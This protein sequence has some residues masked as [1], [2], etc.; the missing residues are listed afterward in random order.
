MPSLRRGCGSV[1]F[2]CLTMCG[3]AACGEDTGTVRDA[4]RTDTSATDGDMMDMGLPSDDVEDS[5]VNDDVV[6]GDDAGD[7]DA[8]PTDAAPPRCGMGID[9]DGDGID[10]DVECLNGTDPFN[11]DSDGDGLTDGEEARYPRIC[12][13]TDRMMQRR[14]TVRCMTDGDCMMGERCLGLSG[15]STDSD[16][17]G[18]S[19]REEDLNLDGT[20]DG[21]MGETDPRLWDTDGDGTSDSM[22]GV[23]ICRPSGLATVVQTGI[24]AGGNTQLGFDPRWGPSARVLGTAGRGAVLLDD[25]I[26]NVSGI[27]AAMPSMGDV[28][29]ESTRVAALITAAVGVGI[30]PVLVGRSLTT[31]EMNP[32][33]TS[34]YRVARSTSASALRDSLI[35]PMVGAPAPGG[36][37]VGVSTEF[38]LD[39]TTVRRTMGS[40][41]GTTDVIVAVSPRS[42]YDNPAVNTAIRANDLVDATGVAESDKGLGFNCQV[43]RAVASAPVEFLW[44]V[45]TSGS[46]GP[47]QVRLG[48]VATQFFTRLQAAGIDFRVGVLTAGNNSLNLDTPGFR[49][50]LGTDALGPRRLCEQVTSVGLGTCPTSPSDTVSPYPF[51]GT[52]EEPTAAAAVGHYT[53]L[54]RTMMGEV[55]PDRRFRAGARVVAFLVTD[56][57]GSNDFTRYFATNNDPQAGT[58]WAPTGVYNTTALSNIIAYFR[59][60][61]VLTFGLLPLTATPC[62]SAAVFDLPRCVV[63]GNGGAIIPIAT[64]T[65]PE[66]SAAMAR[67][68][69]AVAGAVSQFRLTRTAITSTIKVRVRGMDVPRSRLDGFDYDPASNAVVFYGTTFRPR[70]GDEVVISYRLWQACPPRGTTCRADSECCSPFTCR[71]GTCQ[72][73]CTMAGGMCMTNTDCCPPNICISGMCGPPVGCRPTGDV[74]TTDMDCCAPNSCI[75]GRCMVPMP[76]RPRAGMCTTNAD[77]CSTSCVAGRCGCTPESGRCTSAGDCCS[78]SCIGGSCG[79]G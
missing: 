3:L 77:C 74:C 19:D 45:D 6:A 8:G 12:V 52:T 79:P 7:E 70:T 30:T 63:E 62:S 33:I 26:T 46:M 42:L 53:F 78:S 20:I 50:I 9:S 40:A 1:W 5:G 31:H 37:S 10:N 58:R 32:A 21:M 23:P 24:V 67:I 47:Y 68:I 41:A 65:D 51:P 49:W 64:A 75:M 18:V 44:T 28:N 73:P 16:M 4:R 2:V 48:N 22:G 35:M 54:R 27:V 55:N 71:D 25:P 36:R 69:S 14:P 39:V 17:D 60:N 29:A 72:P 43:M 61:M 11:R 13:A 56:E 59:R 34:T 15:T 38:L 76:C 57:P 66:I